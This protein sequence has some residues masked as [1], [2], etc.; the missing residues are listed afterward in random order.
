[1][2]S[3]FKKGD[4][5]A[6]SFIKLLLTLTCS[7][8]LCMTSNSF[9]LAMQPTELPRNLNGI[10]YPEKN[11]ITEIIKQL[12]VSADTKKDAY[13]LSLPL[14]AAAQQGD[15]EAYKKT[16]ASINPLLQ[17]MKPDSFKAWLLGRLLFSAKSINDIDTVNKVTRI[18]S[19]L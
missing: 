2:C 4:Y 18:A 11:S 1:M 6:G 14:M 13:S 19:C 5:M 3:I 10:N 16:L 8:L 7:F 12:Y 9:A 15:T 17:D